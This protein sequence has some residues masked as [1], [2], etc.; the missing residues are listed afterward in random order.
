[1][2]LF[3]Q[4]SNGGFGHGASKTNCMLENE[5]LGEMKASFN[6]RNLFIAPYKPICLFQC[7]KFSGN[8]FGTFWI[9]FILDLDLGRFFG[10]CVQLGL[11]AFGLG[12][13]NLGL[14]AFGFGK[15]IV[16]FVL[17]MLSG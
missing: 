13:L 7:I 11:I 8:M 14:H 15:N 4:I 2:W 12:H 10:S 9:F 5:E 3:L 1:M 16:L 17:F 6:G